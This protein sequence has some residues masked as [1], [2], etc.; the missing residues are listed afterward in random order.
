MTRV[1]AALLVIA[2]FWPAPARAEPEAEPDWLEL[3]RRLDSPRKKERLAAVEAAA[4]MGRERAAAYL[5]PILAGDEDR[6]V[7]LA[8]V[9]ALRSIPGEDAATLLGE[10]LADEDLRVRLAAVEA[11]RRRPE[12]SAE[13]PLARALRDKK[14]E[15]RAAA[16]LALGSRLAAGR[17]PLLVG[18]IDDSEA[19]VREATLYAL[20]AV[21]GEAAVE[22]LSGVIAGDH[23]KKTKALAAEILGSMGSRIALP[24]LVSSLDD[25]DDE[26]LRPALQSAIRKILAQTPARVREEDRPPRAEPEPPLPAAPPKAA[27]APQPTAAPVVPAAPAEKPVEFKLKA[28]KAR[29]VLL[30]LDVLAGKRTAMVRSVNGEWSAR[31]SLAPGRYRYQFIVDGER[32]LDPANPAVERGASLKTVP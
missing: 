7:R 26:V 9:K 5:R 32:T 21:G 27:P 14:P 30:A 2:G 25:A 4:G 19:S 17:A 15:V 3:A 16:A 20:G 1:L 23:K 11:L 6:E 8:A 22:A 28:P 31:L 13:L 24:A 12:A 10:G 29:S 18:G